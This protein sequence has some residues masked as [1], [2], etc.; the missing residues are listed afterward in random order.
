MTRTM[1]L[2][3]LIG[4]AYVTKDF[5]MVNDGTLLGCLA[6]VKALGDKMPDDMLGIFQAEAD[7]RTNAAQPLAIPKT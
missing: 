4:A 2:D 7:R 6:R 5:T 3:Q 1:N